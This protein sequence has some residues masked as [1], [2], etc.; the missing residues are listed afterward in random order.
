MNFPLCKAML[1][2]YSVSLLRASAAFALIDSM[3]SNFVSFSSDCSFKYKLKSPG[4]MLSE[5]GGW[6]DMAR[7]LLYAKQNG[8]AKCPAEG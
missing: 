7:T 1:K 5:Y 3:L 6:F 4:S 8:L 2:F